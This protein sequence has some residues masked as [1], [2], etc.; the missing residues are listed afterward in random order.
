M[1]VN[2][3][4]DFFVDLF[5]YQRKSALDWIVPSAIGLGV[6]AAI[7]VGLGMILAPHPG[8]ETRQKLIE[9]ASTLKG[10]AMDKA[11]TLAD[12]A[13]GQADK[14]RGE[15]AGTSNLSYGEMGSSGIGNNL[16]TLGR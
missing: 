10:K 7:G 13:R 8:P 4:R 5:P 11:K 16:G 12:K 2:D 9:G 1:D 15:L 3:V 6:G 14:A